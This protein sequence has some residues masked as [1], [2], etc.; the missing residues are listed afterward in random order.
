MNGV[1]TIP[2]I[3]EKMSPIVH[4]FQ[5]NITLNNCSNRRQRRA[6]SHLDRIPPKKPPENPK[7]LKTFNFPVVP[8]RVA[9]SNDQ[10]L[11]LKGQFRNSDLIRVNALRESAKHEIYPRCRSHPEDSDLV[12]ALPYGSQV[13]E[14]T[15]WET[16]QHHALGAVIV[17]RRLS[18]DFS[19][20]PPSPAQPLRDSSYQFVSS[21]AA[22]CPTCS[23]AF[24]RQAGN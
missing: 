12:I 21:P 9:V 3:R 20:T 23:R 8:D 24:L 6:G 11:R 22:D 17:S 19:R 4:M 13:D 16:G 5:S 2:N 15:V 7:A 14:G 18:V 10:V 1:K